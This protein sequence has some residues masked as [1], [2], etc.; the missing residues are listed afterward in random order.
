MS[1]DVL[2]P[3]EVESRIRE[4]ANRISMSVSECNNRYVAFLKAS[5]AYD[6]A[7]AHAYLDHDGP[8]HEKR[9]AAEIATKTERDARDVADAAFKYVDRL[10]KS[11]QD[12]L[13]AYQSVGASVRA[14]YAVAGRGEQ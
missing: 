13:R 7:Y 8:A 2:N 11:L 10:S 6:Q 14:M 9:Y 12:E 3:V 1:S 4:I 5:S